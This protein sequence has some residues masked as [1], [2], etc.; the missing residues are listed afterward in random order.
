MQFCYP[1]QKISGSD[2]RSISGRILVSGATDNSIRVWCVPQGASDNGAQGHLLAVLEV[3]VAP[4]V[5]SCLNFNYP[6]EHLEACHTPNIT[7]MM[8]D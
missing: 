7:K 3:V 6:A 2:K 8:H 1:L 4:L 5:A